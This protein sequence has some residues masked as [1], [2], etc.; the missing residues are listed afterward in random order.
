M[1]ELT[2]AEF[3]ERIRSWIERLEAAGAVSIDDYLELGRLWNTLYA[4]PP[5]AA[6]GV[7]PRFMELARTNL[8]KM[9]AALDMTVGRGFAWTSQTHDLVLGGGLD[10]RY[11]YRVR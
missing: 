8:P 9:T 4:D 6:G 3:D 1:L 2:R 11:R 7:N 5:R 10:E